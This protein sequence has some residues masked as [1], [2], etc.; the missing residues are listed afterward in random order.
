MRAA[1]IGDADFFFLHFRPRV[2]APPHFHPAQSGEDRR[3]C[4]M[5]RLKP[6]STMK[7]DPCETK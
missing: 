2:V 1:N 5:T 4:Q 7:I 3:I 6:L